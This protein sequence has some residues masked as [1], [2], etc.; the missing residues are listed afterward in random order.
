[1]KSSFNSWIYNRERKLDHFRVSAQEIGIFFNYLTI[2]LKKQN[3]NYIFT[4]LYE[5]F[6]IKLSTF[7]K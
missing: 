7:I 1:M 5:G 4:V 6:V 3:N 2:F